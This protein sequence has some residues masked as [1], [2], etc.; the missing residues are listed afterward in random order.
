MKCKDDDA[1]A[2][3]LPRSRFQETM[4][5]VFNYGDTKIRQHKK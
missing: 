1:L 2:T 3:V 4:Q 5:A